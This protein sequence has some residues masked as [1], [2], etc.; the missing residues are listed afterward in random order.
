MKWNVTGGSPGKVNTDVV[1]CLTDRKKELAVVK[2]L[3]HAT[4]IKEYQS[5]VE[6]GVVKAPLLLPIE[7]GRAS[8]LLLCS[9]D[10]TKNF[11]S[12][13]E[14]VKIAASL[15]ISTCAGYGITRIAFALNGSK[16][17]SVASL[18]VEGV[19]LGAY[20][21]EKYLREKD[22]LSEKLS[23]TL[24]TNKNAQKRVERDVA[25]TGTIC[26]SVNFARDLVN[27]PSDVKTPLS[28]AKSAQ[29]MAA[30][31][32]LEIEVLDR[33]ELKQQ[34][35]NCLLGV[36]QGSDVNPPVMIVLRYRPKRRPEG[37]RL[38]IGLV[39][40][41]VTFDSGGISIKPSV[42]MWQMKADMAGGAAVLGA[43]RAIALL[44]P[45][46]NVTAVIPS[47]HNAVS[48]RAIHPGHVLQHRSGKT[49]HVDNTDAEGRLILID[50]FEKAS[51]ERVTHMIDLA[52]LTGSCVRALGECMCGGFG[53]NEKFFARVKEAGDRAGELIWQLPL[54]DEYI[55]MMKAPM[56]DINNAGNSPN[57]GA[58]TAALFL[59]EF[60]PER[61]PWVHLDIA[62]PFL[63]TKP[64]KYY[65]EGGTGF[66]VRT[67]IEMVDTAAKKGL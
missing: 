12:W 32:G 26:E 13:D 61:L 36:G 45:E 31:L 19:E 59:K 7:R 58:I 27:E 39:G 64:W 23:C 24:I 54:H 62:G 20:N 10:L 60:V 34:N 8:H 56:A 53:T 52:T 63:I 18:V 57:A 51:E 65:R 2:G 16:G 11:Y 29:D 46:V 5:K 9:I 41:A 30:D 35:F 42:N 28:L 38:N 44:K 37:K 25:R 49:V 47:A 33:D 55:T 15:A 66:G 3:G 22:V 21:Y 50:A 4:A 40:K 1:V 67:L 43:M 48:D 6:E 17:A 14:R